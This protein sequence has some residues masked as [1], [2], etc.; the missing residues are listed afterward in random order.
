VPEVPELSSSDLAELADLAEELAVEAGALVRDGRRRGLRDVGTKSTA[1]D[2]VTEYDRASERLIVSEL[3]SR[4]PHDG[5]VSEEGASRPGTSGIAWLIDPID[6]TTNY[7]YGLPGYA[8]SIAAQVGDRTVV[9]VVHVPVPGETFRAVAGRGA[10][11]DGVAIA[12]SGKADLATALVATGFAYEPSM[13]VRQGEAAA[14]MLGRIRDI[15][16]FGA[17]SVDLCHVASGRVDAYFERGLAPW[18]L[19][20]GELIA[21][22]AGATLGDFR[23]GAPRPGEVLAA[24]PA[25]F[26]QLVTLLTSV[27]A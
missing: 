20:A 1:T 10:T 6:G 5:I 12:C 14:A 13:R 8:V 19:A 4:R 11:L 26:A 2:M 23:G 24:P 16:R 15:R 22:E 18:D 9:G 27:G 25:L 17:A 21:R 3:R 7:L